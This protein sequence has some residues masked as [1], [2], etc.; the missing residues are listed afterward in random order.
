MLE[1]ILPVRDQTHVSTHRSHVPVAVRT[2]RCLRTRCVTRQTHLLF[3]NLCFRLRFSRHNNNL[4]RR[5]SLSLP[6][7]PTTTM[8]TRELYNAASFSD[9][10]VKRANGTTIRAHKIVLCR[11]NEYFNSMCGPDSRFVVSNNPTPRLFMSLTVSTR[12][13]TKRASSSKKTTLPP[14]RACSARSTGSRP[15]RPPTRPGA[16]GSH[17][18]SRLTSTS[19]RL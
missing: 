13:A 10:E 18:A 6:P 7:Q 4:H 15:L 14:S 9:V 17:S 19:R 8:D 3:L 12:N 1:A 2:C 5:S 11:N 16:S